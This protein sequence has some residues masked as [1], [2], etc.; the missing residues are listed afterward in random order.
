MNTD[1][2]SMSRTKKKRKARPWW[3][4]TTISYL[5]GSR[6]TFRYGHGTCS[7][8]I[9][10][11]HHSFV[12]H[13]CFTLSLHSRSRIEITFLVQEN[14]ALIL[15]TIIFSDGIVVIRPLWATV[16]FSWIMVF[17]IVVNIFKNKRYWFPSQLNGGMFAI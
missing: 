8:I 11:W 7:I 1:F 16:L 6:P 14:S 12:I 9:V 2:P 17:Y 15:I 10:Q 5:Q 13:S 3:N 4:V